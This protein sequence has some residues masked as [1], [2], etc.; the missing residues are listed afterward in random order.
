LTAA[1]SLRWVAAFVPVGGL[2]SKEAKAVRERITGLKRNLGSTIAK[3]NTLRSHASVDR[4]ADVSEEQVV[5]GEFPWIF[6]G[7]DDGSPGE[8][9]Q[10]NKGWVGVWYLLRLNAGTV[11]MN[12][13]Y[14]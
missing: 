8:W 9:R 10:A 4:P 2:T 12:V 11:S 13:V 3:Y 7:L 14:P 5:S 6:R 1:N